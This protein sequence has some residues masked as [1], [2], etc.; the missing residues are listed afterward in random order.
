VVDDQTGRGV[1][2]VELETTYNGKYVT[3]SSGFVAF[4]E[5]GLMNQ[6]V[7]FTITS[8]GYQFPKD[9]FGINGVALEIK[10]GGSATLKIKRI[11]IAERLYR[12]TGYGIY[13]D[14]VLLD[15]PVPIKE[16]L[17][18]GKVTGQDSVLS[19]VYN[20]KIYWFWGDTARPSYPLGLFRTSGATSELPGKGGLDPNIGINLNYI[21]GDDGFSRAMVNIKG[22]GLFWIGGLL[23]VSDD[24]GRQRMV[25]HVSQMKSL[26]ERLGRY[27]IV[28][29]DEKQA[30]EMLK[31]VPLDAKL[32][33]DGHPFRAKGAD[34]VDYF[35]F[36]AP[37]PCVRTRADWK[38]VTDLSS[39]EAFT[40]LKPGTHLGVKADVRKA[41]LDR[42]PGGRLR[43]AWK[44]AT[45]PL[46]PQQLNELVSAGRIKREESPF[47]L[48]DV[49][50][51]KPITLHGGS[52]YHNDFRK[53]FVMIGLQVGGEESNLG[54]VWYSEA[55][56]P[57]GPWVA[58]R[59]I[60][61]HHK[62]D[63]YNPTQHP[64]LD[65]EGGRFIY[66]DGTYVNTFSGNPITTPYYNYNQV[67]YRLDLADPRL[68]LSQ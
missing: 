40:C 28:F 62:Q 36:P 10:P 57:E 54:E 51:K 35:Y 58:A 37:Y 2:L 31:D 8:H 14:S 47:R 13:R 24:T 26:S 27:L 19:A 50:S 30:F 22:E 48:Q 65:A 53:K 52:V 20:G 25:A 45:D 63:F 23:T 1:P 64:E 17:L 66:F 61:T 44:K 9:A 32:A 29:D 33:P 43:W 60:V 67:M 15:R 56:R 6:K 68:H 55:D 34:G 18:N 49:E 3:D 42:D 12:V 38:S 4:S 16:P 39:Y 11:N 59:K 5:P 21:V 46:S 7:F 41:A